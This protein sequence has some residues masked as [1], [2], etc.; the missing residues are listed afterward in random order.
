[1]E[2]I[3]D[4][5]LFVSTEIYIISFFCHFV[6][7]VELVFVCNSGRKTKFEKRKRDGACRYVCKQELERKILKPN[8]AN[9]QLDN[10]IEKEERSFYFW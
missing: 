1:M 4:R 8:I 3:L 9:I 2:E 5:K 6:K 7:K 10:V